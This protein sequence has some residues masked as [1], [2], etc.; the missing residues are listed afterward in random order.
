[1]R[2]RHLIVGATAGL[3]SATALARLLK[4]G[5]ECVKQ[6]RNSVKWRNSWC[7]PEAQWRNFRPWVS[8][9]DVVEVT[10]RLSESQRLMYNKP[11]AVFR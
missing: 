2:M 1:M 7:K 10:S 8:G 9:N 11:E 4:M 6:V 3:F 5:D